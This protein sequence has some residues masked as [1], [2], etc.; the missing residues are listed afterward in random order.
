MGDVEP[1]PLPGV[2]EDSL[3]SMK[4][5]ES[6]RT[7][8]TVSG[9]TGEA[10]ARDVQEDMP[11]EDIMPQ[12]AES[13]A[14]DLAARVTEDTGGSGDPYE[15]ASGKADELARQMTDDTD[16]DGDMNLYADRKV[17]GMKEDLAQ[18]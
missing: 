14:N 9:V 7:A 10:E 3:P 12:S 18:D 11:L 15:H 6:M 2:R 13:A 8:E 16:A 4:S 1:R 17:E 5:M